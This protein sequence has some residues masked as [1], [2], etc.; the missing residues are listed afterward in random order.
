MPPTAV[1]EAVEEYR[2]ANDRIGN[3][4]TDCLEED[5][6][7]VL[8]GKEFFDDYRRWCHDNGFTSESKTHFFDT[9][10]RRGIMSAS[11]NLHGKHMKNVVLGYKLLPME[12]TDNDFDQ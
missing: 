11:A 9:L 6:D 2:K 4:M 12:I 10:R 5:P 8:T 1:R 7:S 3:Y